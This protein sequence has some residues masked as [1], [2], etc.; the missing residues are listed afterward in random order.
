MAVWALECDPLLKKLMP[1]LPRSGEFL[2]MSGKSTL[3]YLW[4]LVT[5]K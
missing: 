5:Q 1:W 2:M 4:I 3:R